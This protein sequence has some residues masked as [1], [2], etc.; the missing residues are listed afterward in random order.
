MKRRTFGF[1]AGRGAL[2]QPKPDLRTS[3]GLM[4]HSR[5]H[6]AMAT[7]AAVVEA[8]LKPNAPRADVTLVDG[9]YVRRTAD[10]PKDPRTERQREADA[11]VRQYGVTAKMPRM[12]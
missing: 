12:R 3:E 10:A 5:A 9:Q 7:V 1:V 2:A 4:S 6:G 8:G 11:W